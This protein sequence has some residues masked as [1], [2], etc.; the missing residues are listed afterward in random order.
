MGFESLL[1]IGIIWIGFAL[2]F[3]VEILNLGS[4][5]KPIPQEFVDALEP[6][7]Y[8]KNQ[9]YLFETTRLSLV[10]SF[11][12]PVIWTIAIA[13]GLF[14]YLD[15]N[16]L[17]LT[18]HEVLRGLLFF[19]VIGFFGWLIHLPFS[20]Y[21]TFGIEAKFGFN[22]MKLVTFCFDQ[23]KGALLGIILGGVVLSGVIWFFLTFNKIG[24]LITWAALITFEVC[25][26]FIA[27]TWIMPLFNKFTLLPDGSLKDE[28]QK[29]AKNQEFQISGIF[30]MD[31]SKRSNKANAFFTG[32]GKNKRIVLFDTLLEKFS[33]SELV[34]ILAHEVGHY[35]KGHILRRL[36]ISFITTLLMFYLF[37]VFLRYPIGYLAVNVKLQSIHVAL[38]SFGILYSPLSRLFGLFGLYI[39]RKHEFEADEF[40]IRTYQHSSQLFS[41]LKKLSLENL[42]NLTPHPIKVLSQYSH[43]PVVERLQRI[44]E[45]EVAQL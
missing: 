33:D 45:E 9:D 20:L 41:A 29:Y 39:S 18:N 6:D 40:S 28:I 1:V 16:L 35:K 44:R 11:V 30:T 5:S 27:P 37:G 26:L 43:P 3:V 36:G 2:H 22:R 24:W 34:A 32:F 12:S 42:S 10:Q 19:A 14:E 4:A 8:Q 15:S 25:L 31:G 7:A 23:I 13:Y 21:D 38:L 17:A